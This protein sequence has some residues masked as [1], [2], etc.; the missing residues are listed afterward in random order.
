MADRRA[1]VV[2]RSARAGAERRGSRT[3]SAAR[4]AGTLQGHPSGSRRRRAR[5]HRRR[6]GR[7]RV[8]DAPRSRTAAWTFVRQFRVGPSR[9]PLWLVLGVEGDRHRCDARAAGRR[10]PLRTL[11]TASDPASRRRRRAGRCACRRTRDRSSS[12]VAFTSGRRRPAIA[13]QRDSRRMRRRRAGRRKSPRTITR[14]T[15]KDAYVVDDIALPLDNPWRRNVRPGDIQF[16]AGRHRRR[17]SRSTATSGSFA[18]CTNR[19]RR[20]AGGASRPACTSR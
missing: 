10:T 7:A 6:R 19:R 5:V 8:D 12:A 14:S 17:A 2:R 9:E 1:P 13:S 4:G 11:P 15:A 20:R 16:L 3:R 18:A